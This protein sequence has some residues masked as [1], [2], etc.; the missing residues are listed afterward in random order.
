M[1]YIH[2]AMLD[3][4]HGDIVKFNSIDM[5]SHWLMASHSRS[6]GWRPMRGESL[7]GTMGVVLAVASPTKRCV[8]CALSRLTRRD[9]SLRH[10]FF[11]QGHDYKKF[12][13]AV[14]DEIR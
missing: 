8:S 5:L 1:V 3:I 11:F 14:L 2:T 10:D 6:M 9:H 13:M 7:E 12:A 4:E